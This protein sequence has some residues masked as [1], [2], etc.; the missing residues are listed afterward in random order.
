M[1]PVAMAAAAASQE[2]PQCVTG[3]G[4]P[5]AAK[6]TG[7]DTG[8][9]T[10]L[11]TQ[12][13]Q[14]PV[15]S[16]IPS[17]AANADYLKPSYW[18]QR[19]EHERQYEWLSGYTPEVRALLQRHVPT[20]ARVLILGNGTS[21]LPLDMAR[22]G[23]SSIVATDLSSLAVQTMR[24]AAAQQGLHGIQWRPA[25]M[26]ALPFDSGSFEAV[27]EKGTLD[28]LFVDGGSP[29]E[30]APEVQL[31]VDTVLSEVFRCVS[32]ARRH[33]SAQACHAPIA[34][35]CRCTWRELLVAQPWMVLCCAGCWGPAECL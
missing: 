5:G 30:M 18:D 2:G 31:R 34:C 29:W 16:T 20:A 8:A 10:D 21:Q 1:T 14:V 6:D 25:D 28:V 11:P 17:P 12:A 24:E 32:S 15:S 22:D 23:V 9:Q 13:Q 35:A 26:M 19:F 33:M 27:V 7:A 3:A 4:Q